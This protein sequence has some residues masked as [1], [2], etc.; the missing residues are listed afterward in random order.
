MRHSYNSK[1]RRI[2]ACR[3]PSNRCSSSNRTL[4][5][6]LRPSAT[7]WLPSWSHRKEFKCSQLPLWTQ[8]ALAN[9]LSQFFQQES[10]S[11]Q[12]WASFSP[13]TLLSWAALEAR[14][15]QSKDQCYPLPKSFPPR[16]SKNKAQRVLQCVR[17]AHSQ[18]PIK[19]QMERQTSCYEAK[20]IFKRLY[21]CRM[22]TRNKSTHNSKRF[23]VSW[24]G[25]RSTTRTNIDIHVPDLAEF[26]RQV[27]L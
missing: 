10:C 15:G 11:A 2:S 24:S 7:M 17:G 25:R 9:K 20:R 4:P 6:R 26:V 13:A 23:I 5:T 16:L 12:S 1:W 18:V 8:L 19:K 21:T 3:R 27:V 22:L 14:K